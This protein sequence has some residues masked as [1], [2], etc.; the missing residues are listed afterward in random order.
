MQQ[1]LTGNMCAVEG[2]GRHGCHPEAL[3]RIGFGGMEDSSYVTLGRKKMYV[4]VD[5]SVEGGQEYS[6]L[7]ASVL[8]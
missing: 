4:A 8:P 2:L 5:N 1:V 3:G 6:C 7:V